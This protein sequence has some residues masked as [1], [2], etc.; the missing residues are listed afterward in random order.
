MH[1]SYRGISPNHDAELD[2]GSEDYRWR[3]FFIDFISAGGMT[4][5]A[6]TATKWPLRF[7]SGSLLTTPVSGTME[8]YNDKIYITN[9][10]NR[11]AIDRTGEAK[12]TTTTVANSNTEDTV[13]TEVISAN[14]LKVG[15]IIK[16]KAFGQYT[17]ASAADTFNINVYIGTTLIGTIASPAGIKASNAP[18]HSESILTIRTAGAG[19]T[20]SSHIDMIAVTSSSHT[21]TPTTAI[22]T[23]NTNNITVKIQWSSAKAD[24]IAQ[25]DQ[26]FVEFKN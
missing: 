4:F 15:N 13:F 23:I 24:N 5:G 11:K 16:I 26:A 18:W 2:L 20:V 19:G 8:F 9:V 17:T 14:T 6:G 12:V 21:N 10:V 1:V 22:N 25:I 7:T 3:D